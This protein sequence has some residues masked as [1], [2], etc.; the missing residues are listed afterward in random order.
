MA[1]TMEKLSSNKVKLS[2]NVE[3]SKL[4]EGELIRY[5]RM[6]IQLARQLA[7]APGVSERIASNA[8]DLRRLM[9]RGVVD[10]ERQLRG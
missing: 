1:V 3:A 5:F 2:F 7:Q 4:D 8:E 6:I 10:A 9:D